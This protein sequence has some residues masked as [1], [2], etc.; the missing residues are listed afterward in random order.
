MTN[1]RN[2]QL[3]MSLMMDHTMNMYISDTINELYS[4]TKEILQF[5]QIRLVVKSK[6]WYYGNEDVTWYR[7]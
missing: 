6:N 4:K 7:I 1:S 5:W 2:I 3:S